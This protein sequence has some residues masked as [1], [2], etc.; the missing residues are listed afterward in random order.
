M[1]S[2]KKGVEVWNEDEVSIGDKILKLPE[3]NCAYYDLNKMKMIFS[4]VGNRCFKIKV[5]W[6]NEEYIFGVSYQKYHNELPEVFY[7]FTKVLHHK[8]DLM[9]KKTLH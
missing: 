7:L 2:S 6:K 8:L 5:S 4:D 3:G 1:V 9:G